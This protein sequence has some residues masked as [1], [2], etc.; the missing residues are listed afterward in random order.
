MPR[1]GTQVRPLPPVR[2]EAMRAAAERRDAT[3]LT[4]VYKNMR[5][6]VIPPAPPNSRR[7]SPNGPFGA[8]TE[9]SKKASAAPQAD[10]CPGRARSA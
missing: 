2:V 5:R 10:R 6:V 9:Q 7:T 3:I 1:L 4:G 8:W